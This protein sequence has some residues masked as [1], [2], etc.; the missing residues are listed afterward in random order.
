VTGLP[1]VRPAAPR[2]AITLARCH[3]A[4]WRE[5][6]SGIV[7][8]DTL[9]ARTGDLEARILRWDD[10]LRT[11]PRRTWLAAVGDE[12]LGFACAGEG[13]DDDL[14]H[15]PELYALYVRASAHGSGLADRLVG[16][17]I[18]FAP[19]YLW[20]AAENPRAL[21]YYQ[22]IGFR[23]DGRSKTDHYLGGIR[24]VRMTRSDGSRVQR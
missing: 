14:Q 24:E 5:A 9:T 17:A 21:R 20:V 15:L 13:R 12:A 22:K 2:D 1:E 23:L 8:A 18:G 4:C 3:V 16:P 7:P 6:Y 19:A 11:G 10:I